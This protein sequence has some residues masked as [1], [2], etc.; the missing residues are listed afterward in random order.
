MLHLIK[1]GRVAYIAGPI[2][3]RVNLNRGAF[4]DAAALLRKA[5]F[6][7]VIPHDL[8][9]HADTEAYDWCDYLRVCLAKICLH[10]DVLVTLPDWEQSPGAKLEV[11]VWRRLG[12]EPMPLMKFTDQPEPS[13]T[14]NN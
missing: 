5:G 14:T 13:L 8:F 7:P 11:D 3:G 6:I 4:E 1:G 12:R 2:T 9:M 10:A